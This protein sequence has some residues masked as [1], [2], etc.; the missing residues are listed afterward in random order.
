MT[1]SDIR[2]K[3]PGAPALGAATARIVATLAALTVAG[4]IWFACRF[5]VPRY[6]AHLMDAG[7][8]PSPALRGLLIAS[9][10]VARYF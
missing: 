4:S 5:I 6:E 9:D 3:P 10:Y 8:R 2:P 7:L 1:T